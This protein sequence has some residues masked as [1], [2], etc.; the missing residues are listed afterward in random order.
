[1][2]KIAIIRE[3]LYYAQNYE[4]DISEYGHT[5]GRTNTTRQII[6]TTKKNIDSFLFG[7]GYGSIKEEDTQ[8]KSGF[9]YGI[10]G[11]TRDIV[12]GGWIVMFLTILIF[13]KVILTNQSTNY[14]FTWVL[15]LIIFMVFVFTHFSYSS[16]FA[17]SLKITYILAIICAFINSPSHSESLD[18]L[19]NKYLFSE[20]R[21]QF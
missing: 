5:I 4:T 17:T 1:M 7:F 10:V 14:K 11:F 21:K 20:R 13:S 8:A 12:S 18:I 15:R 2:D 9:G 19:V 6:N 16:D 3:A